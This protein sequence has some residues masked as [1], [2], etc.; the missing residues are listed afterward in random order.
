MWHIEQQTS[1][2]NSKEIEKSFTKSNSTMNN[3]SLQTSIKFN[4]NEID[5]FSSPPQ[6]LGEECNLNIKNPTE[7]FPITSTPI[8]IS[9]PRTPTTTLDIITLKSK[10][11]AVKRKKANYSNSANILIKLFG[12]V[13]FV[14][15]YDFLR[16]QAKNSNT[17][18]NIKN[19][20]THSKTVLQHLKNLQNTL[21]NQIQD[22]ERKTLFQ[23]NEFNLYPDECSSKI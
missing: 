19:Y 17:H 5:I 18:F 9:I 6:Q 12:E 4:N 20:K 11:V 14:K 3:N 16:K 22:I 2:S 7:T 15:R 23:N 10:T 8:Q 13:D 1:S 21:K